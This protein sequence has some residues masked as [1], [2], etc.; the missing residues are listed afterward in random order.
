[1]RGCLRRWA[2]GIEID[3]PGLSIYQATDDRAR[4]VERLRP[5]MQPVAQ[6]V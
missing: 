3:C 4:T 6:G 2:G 1:L 5:L